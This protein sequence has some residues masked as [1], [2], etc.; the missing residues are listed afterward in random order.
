MKRNV[1]PETSRPPRPWSSHSLHP[2][3]RRRR[4]RW[5]PM[6]GRRERS[7]TPADVSCRASSLARDPTMAALRGRRIRRRSSH[8]R[9]ALTAPARCWT[10]CAASCAAVCRS[11]VSRN[12]TGVPVANAR[13]PSFAVFATAKTAPRTFEVR[14]SRSSD[15]ILRCRHC[16]SVAIVP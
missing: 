8:R 3:A 11:G 16:D 13:A 14:R 5:S 15:D 10:T 6:P 7:S 12:A 1:V 2:T 9:A 4:L